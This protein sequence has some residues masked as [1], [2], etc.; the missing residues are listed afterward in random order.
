MFLVSLVH[1]QRGQIVINFILKKKKKIVIKKLLLI[2][3]FN[4]YIDYSSCVMT[5]LSSFSLNRA[6]LMTTRDGLPLDNHSNLQCE[7]K[8]SLNNIGWDPRVSLFY[9][10]GVSSW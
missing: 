1:Y 3:A 8:C 2:W 7:P 5:T 6:T 9:P 10:L 4:I